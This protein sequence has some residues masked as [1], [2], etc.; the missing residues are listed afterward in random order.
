MFIV[1]IWNLILIRFKSKFQWLV[2]GL[3]NL[4]GC[5]RDWINFHL[6]DGKNFSWRFTTCVWYC[7]FLNIIF[8]IPC[9]FFY[10]PSL[11]S[12]CSYD[13]L[14]TEIINLEGSACF[15]YRFLVILY[16]IESK[17]S[18][19]IFSQEALTE[20]R[21]QTKK[22]ENCTWT[23]RTEMWSKS[24]ELNIAECVWYYLDLGK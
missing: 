9:Q 8:S 2:R 5:G 7:W 22:K 3:I 13:G 23:L 20:K 19:T 4:V 14:C 1:L 12:V 24:P 17:S 15:Q 18:I 16:L 21:K 6:F 10:Y 11:F